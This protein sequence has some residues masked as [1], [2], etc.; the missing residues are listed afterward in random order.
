MAL[1]HQLIEK[2][3]HEAVLAVLP[4]A[5]L[6]TVKVRPCPEPKF[7][8]YQATAL[9]SLAKTRKLNPRQ[10]AGDVNAKLDLR[11]WCDSAEIAGPGFLNFRLKPAALAA[12]LESAVRGDHL[13]FEPAAQPR[14]VVV[15]FSSPNVA[16]PMHVGHIRSTILGE[17]LTR[18]LRLLGHRVITDNHLGDWGTQYGM[19]L[20]GWKQHMDPVAMQQEPI[21]EMERLYKL[22]HAAAAQDPAVLEQA[23]Q[24]LV[25]LQSGD[26]E[27]LRLWREM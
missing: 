22:V 12:A 27:N 13:F 3:L 9:I 4:D 20:V 11:E 26:A 16:K 14:T 24:E 10:L 25:K 8:D 1:P 5:D 2:R 7:G 15:D 21:A 6:S 18:T 19:L 23:K 17:C